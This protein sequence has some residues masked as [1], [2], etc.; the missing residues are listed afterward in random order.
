M[1]TKSAK[2][3]DHRTD[4]WR[5]PLC[6]I[7][8]GRRPSFKRMEPKSCS[9]RAD[10]E[11]QTAWRT[12]ARRVA[13]AKNKPEKVRLVARCWRGDRISRRTLEASPV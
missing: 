13:A 1:R 9:E 12:V 7:R 5:D 3:P 2:A 4:A 11:T 10:W 6:G 8:A